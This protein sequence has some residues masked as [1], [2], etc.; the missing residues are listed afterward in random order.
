MASRL[1]WTIIRSK[2][3][4]CACQHAAQTLMW[5]GAFLLFLTL[6]EHG[7]C[8]SAKPDFYDTIVSIPWWAK[9]AH[10]ANLL[11]ELHNTASLRRPVGCAEATKF[12][13]QNTRHSIERRIRWNENWIQWALSRVYS[14]LERTQDTDLLIRGGLADCAERSQILK[15][16]MEKSGSKCR[17]V[18]LDGHVV[19]EVTSK[20]VTQVADPDYGLVYPMGID[21]LVQPENRDMVR[22]KLEC[23]GYDGEVIETYLSILYSV[24]NNRASEVGAPISPRLARIEQLCS[25]MVWGLPMCLMAAGLFLSKL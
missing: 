20:G 1:T 9:R 3:A 12:V 25:V 2:I 17:F 19:L 10:E 18:G 11:S 8:F 7:S 5:G 16:I 6:I 24:E 13:N 21:E 14:P 23:R 22:K 15:S 4:V